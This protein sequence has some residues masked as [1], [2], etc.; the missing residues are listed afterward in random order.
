MDLKYI[1]IASCAK[2]DL[3]IHTFLKDNMKISGEEEA[4]QLLHYLYILS[5]SL[6]PST[7][8]TLCCNMVVHPL[9]VIGQ[10]SGG[11]VSKYLQGNRFLFPIRCKLC[12]VFLIFL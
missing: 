3:E 2:Q 1:Y 11:V 8:D 10:T 6:S 9:S 12:N 4:S 7:L 5:Q